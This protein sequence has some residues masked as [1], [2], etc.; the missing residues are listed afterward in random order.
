MKLLV[1]EDDDALRVALLRL[2]G[3]WGYA[4]EAAATAGEI[5]Q[6]CL[7]EGSSHCIGCRLS[8]LSSSRL[9]CLPR[10]TGRSSWQSQRKRAAAAVAA[11]LQEWRQQLSCQ[12]P[13]PVAS[14]LHQQRCHL[15]ACRHAA[16]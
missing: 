10:K 5:A 16:A 2:L 15:A 1:V 6:Q 12:L 7:A 3:Q 13:A 4:T 14:M 11:A 8:W 9:L